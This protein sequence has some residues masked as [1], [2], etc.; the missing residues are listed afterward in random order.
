[1]AEAP[2][3]LTT[4]ADSI[5]IQ[6]LAQPG[7]SKAGIIRSDPRGLVVALQ[8]P[9][10]GGRANEELIGLLSK[11]LRVPRSD[12]HLIR[13]GTSRAK[14]IRVTTSNASA[15]AAQIRALLPAPD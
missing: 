10:E 3:W 7:K 2:G 11:A 9:P 4:S 12:V 1:M 14:T 13:G 8:A 6:I 15:V 5:T